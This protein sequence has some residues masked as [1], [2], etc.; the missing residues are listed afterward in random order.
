MG[1]GIYAAA[2]AYGLGFVPLATERYDL[3]LPEPVWSSPPAQALVA[4]VRSAHFKEA[5]A[6]LGGYDT[7]ETGREAWIA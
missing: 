3:V 1:L 6:A 7:S 5:V 4:G 2:A